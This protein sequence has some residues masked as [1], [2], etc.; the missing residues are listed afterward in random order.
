[1]TEKKFISNG[2]LI[3]RIVI[4][5]LVIGLIIAFVSTEYLKKTAVNNLASDDAK[6]TAQLVFETM[7]TRMQEGW[8]KKDLDKIIKRLEHIRTG[9][10]IASYRSQSV[11][12]IFGVVPRDKKIVDSDPL[13]QRS[14]KGEELFSVDEE[15][16]LVRFLYPMKT[17]ENCI[18]CHSNSKMGE[19]NGVLDISFPQSDIKISLDT[20][21]Y[22]FI[23]LLI[24]FL[25]ILSYVFFLIINLKMVKPIVKLTNEIEKV[26]QS[27]DLSKR[28]EIDTNIKELGILQNSFN[29]LLETIKYYYDRLLETIY[30]D[31]LTNVANYSRL[32]KDIETS[33]S[34]I[35]LASL[36]INSFGKIN[37]V[38]GARV[39]DSLLV[40]FASFLTNYIGNEGRVYRLYGDEFAL[41]YKKTISNNDI[42]DLIVKLREKKFY[43]KDIDFTLDITVGYVSGEES[44]LEHANIALK[45]AKNSYKQKAEY[46]ES[47]KVKDEDNN[48]LV[49]AKKLE[50]AIKKDK[51]VPYFMPMKNVKSG[52]IDKYE[53]LIRLIEDDTVY[54]PDKF[55]EVSHA[56]GKYHI[57]TQTVIKKAFEYFKDMENIKFSINF[58]LS[59]ITNEQTRG[60][61]I[62]SLKSFKYSENVII[63]LL[64]T[65]EISDFELLNR[66]INEV[67]QYG[68]KIAIDDF[69]S[70]YSNFNYILNL[71]VDIVKLDSSLVENIYTDQSSAVVVSN[72]VR[73]A[74][75]LGLT[76]VAE[77]VSNE[78]IE[79]ILT[80]HEV[81]YLQGYHIGMPNKNI[82]KER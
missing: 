79:R 38:Y 2:T 55:M 40:D 3:A 67:K 71:D 42:K 62:E 48:H 65:E 51:L 81:D 32:L 21:S 58:A 16:G 68:A 39:A 54:T 82:V 17:T 34:K 13:I 7:N 50:R 31:E 70:G 15:K 64:E 41:L 53:T 24:G 18:I 49:W 63:E 78:H 4:F 57:I 75:E 1:M 74:K 61:L 35:S 46:N 66:F 26:E 12:E 33:S 8:T 60:L 52:K 19:V 80:I 69:G 56:S 76:V 25:S 14:M 28:A 22:Y 29:K 44:I 45:S 6:K 43:Y 30:T 72:I 59:D 20:M 37:R 9:M 77:K 36:D 47:L 10:S 5:I 73:V 27:R 23:A 11:E